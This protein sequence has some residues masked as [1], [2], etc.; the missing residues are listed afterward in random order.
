M[1]FALSA[2]PSPL[3][4]LWSQPLDKGD[5]DKGDSEGPLSV[6]ATPPGT[7][8]REGV[9]VSRPGL[10]LRTQELRGHVKGDSGI[11]R[12]ADKNFLMCY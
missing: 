1:G 5:S 12:E 11:L 2:S 4:L 9:S 7:P 3:P 10:R 8:L 6:V